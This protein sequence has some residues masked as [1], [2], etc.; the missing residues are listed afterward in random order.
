VLFARC[1]GASNPCFSS[2]TTSLHGVVYVN[3]ICS[4]PAAGLNPKARTITV[5]ASADKRPGDKEAKKMLICTAPLIEAPPLQEV[6]VI[7]SQNM[8]LEG[9]IHHLIVDV[10]L[11]NTL[12]TH[13]P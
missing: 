7:C 3:A 2:T 9:N 4:T 13:V 5:Y 6:E 11:Q 12:N 8:F 1:L 10:M